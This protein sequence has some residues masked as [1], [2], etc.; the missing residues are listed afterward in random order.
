MVIGNFLSRL[1]VKGE[2]DEAVLAPVADAVVQ[3]TAD[4][5]ADMLYN[6]LVSHYGHELRVELSG[7]EARLVCEISGEVV[8]RG[9]KMA[10]AKA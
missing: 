4:R 9:K 8:M 6:A 5:I 2:T 7:D 1:W 3:L 10:E